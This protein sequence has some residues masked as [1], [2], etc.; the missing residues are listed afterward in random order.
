M[1]YIGDGGRERCCE[2]VLSKGKSWGFLESRKESQ[3]CT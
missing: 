3:N 1:F 2:R